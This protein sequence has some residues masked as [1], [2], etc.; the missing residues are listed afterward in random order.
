M[1][2]TLTTAVKTEKKRIL[3]VDDQPANTR[4]VRLCLEQTNQYV[5]R[6]E[7][8]ARAALSAAEQFDP[9]LILLDVMM[10][11]MDGGELAASFRANPK[12]KTVPIVFLTASITKGEVV[13]H[14]G[15]IGG[16]SFLA[17]PVVLKEMV[18]C[19]K[20]HLGE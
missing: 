5:V 18:A 20:H 4:L 6:E 10:P 14:G 2:S 16:N 8:H 15:Q 13:A 7:N 9:H 3:A 19:L 17:K 12:L 1:T 11:G